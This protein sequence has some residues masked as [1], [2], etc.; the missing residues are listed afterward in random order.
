M[1]FK[2]VSVQSVCSRLI[3]TRR[4]HRFISEIYFVL[5]YVKDSLSLY[6]S[7][8]AVR[9]HETRLV[10]SDHFH[11]RWFFVRGMQMRAAFLH[12]RNLSRTFIS[13]GVLDFLTL[14]ANL[15]AVYYG[16]RDDAT[17]VLQS[18]VLTKGEQPRLLGRLTGSVPRGGRRLHSLGRGIC[19]RRD[20]R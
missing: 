17:R 15:I 4:N 12:R 2:K 3:L 18:L 5:F 11:G 6:D 10:K 16:D 20:D 9:H 7:G 19:W 13:L 1:I 8:A 14:G